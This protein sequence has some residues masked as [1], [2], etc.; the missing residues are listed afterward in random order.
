VPLFG[1]DPH[2]RQ[3]RRH[4]PPRALAV[5]GQKQERNLPPPQLVDEN[6]GPGN[7]FIAPVDDAIHVDQES[8]SHLLPHSRW[9]A[10]EITQGKQRAQLVRSISEPPAQVV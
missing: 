3:L 1:F 6:I 8:C 9:N 5:V 4:I 2:P 7:H 10:P